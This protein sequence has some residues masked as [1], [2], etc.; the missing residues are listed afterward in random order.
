M[1]FLKVKTAYLCEEI[2]LNL[3][4]CKSYALSLACGCCRLDEWKIIEGC[5]PV[6]GR[7]DREFLFE[8]SRFNF[9]AW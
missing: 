5:Y 1:S 8:L 3:C 2:E 4:P 7:L 6:L 9:G